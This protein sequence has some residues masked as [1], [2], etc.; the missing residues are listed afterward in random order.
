MQELSSGIRFQYSIIQLF[1]FCSSFLR[2]NLRTRFVYLAYFSIFI[3]T[4]HSL[5]HFITPYIFFHGKLRIS[6]LGKRN[7]IY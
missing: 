6:I 5:A 2:Y 1:L 4:L 7:D 3:N